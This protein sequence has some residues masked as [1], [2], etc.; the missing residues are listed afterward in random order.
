MLT[1][2]FFVYI[3]IRHKAYE[4]F[5]AVARDLIDVRQYTNRQAL[6]VRGG[7]NGGLLVSNF[8]V[9]EPALCQSVICEVSQILLSGYLDETTTSNTAYTTAHL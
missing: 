2:V 1:M 9:R 3:L 8:F 5:E 7:S 6:A 4:D